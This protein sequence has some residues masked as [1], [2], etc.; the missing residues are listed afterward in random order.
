MAEYDQNVLCVKIPYT[1]CDLSHR[2]MYMYVTYEN[3]LKY[4]SAAIVN[5]ILWVIKLCLKHG[6]HRVY[7]PS[8]TFPA[9][10]RRYAMLV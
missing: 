4:L 9:N 6:A 5:A 1:R 10:T 8:E 7:R 2:Y 3:N